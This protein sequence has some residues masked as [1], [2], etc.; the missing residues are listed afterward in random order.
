M[1]AGVECFEVRSTQPGV[2][3]D[4]RLVDTPPEGVPLTPQPVFS[5]V[6]N[7]TARPGVRRLPVMYFGQAPVL[8]D[9]D[10]E[11]VIEGLGSYLDDVLAAAK[12]PTFALRTCELDSFQGVLAGDLYNRS[13]FS[14]VLARHDVRCRDEPFIHMNSDRTW[15]RRGVPNFIPK[16]FVY[17][18]RD[19]ELGTVRPS[20]A[21]ALHG[22]ASTR[23]GPNRP[24]DIHA[25]A[26]L[27]KG[28][29][30]MGSG[31]PSALADDL[32]ISLERS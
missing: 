3:R 13:R 17:E 6:A 8:G 24:Q 12:V 10:L 31:D 5:V 2:L 22:L 9:R 15:G 30:V 16:F 11:V 26:R 1:H 23:L 29:V 4:S 25:L 27:T 19:A 20:A 32:R 28:L 21:W 18:A 7:A 14:R